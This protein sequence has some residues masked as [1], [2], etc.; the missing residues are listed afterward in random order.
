MYCDKLIEQGSLDI[1]IGWSD[2]D[3]NCCELLNI[4]DFTP[5]DDELLGIWVVAGAVTDAVAFIP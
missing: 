2:A 1:W 3:P 5:C 4:V